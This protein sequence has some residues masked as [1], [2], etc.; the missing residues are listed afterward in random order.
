MA[1]RHQALDTEIGELDAQIEPLVRAA[2]PQL[3]EVFGVGPET[4]GQLLATAGDNP[5]RMRSE[6]AFAHLCGAAPIPA[7]SGRTHRHRLN[8]GGDR[9]ANSA[10][11]TIV[12]VRM[13]Y[14]ERTR[15][16]VDRRTRQ[17]LSKKEIILCLK[18]FVAREIYRTITTRPPAQTTQTDRAQ[19]A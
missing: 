11:Y 19:A 9:A 6:A 17:G 1:R 5:E 7:S 4:A 12:I 18:R 13:R 8:R 14:D 16:Y 3:L 2:A 15:A 10:L